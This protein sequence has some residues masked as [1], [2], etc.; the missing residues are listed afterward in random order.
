V[1]PAPA[2]GQRANAPHARADSEP[3]D[4]RRSRLGVRRWAFDVRCS[5]FAFL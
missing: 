5:M 2:S 4:V 1:R 3:F